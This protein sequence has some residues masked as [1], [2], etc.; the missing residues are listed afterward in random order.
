[1]GILFTHRPIQVSPQAFF[2]I[3]AP[4]NGNTPALDNLVQPSFSSLIF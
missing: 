2:Y 1:M 3:D 4:I